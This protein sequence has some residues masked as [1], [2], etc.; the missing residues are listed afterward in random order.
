MRRYDN[1]LAVALTFC[2]GIA[3]YVIANMSDVADGYLLEAAMAIKARPGLYRGDLK[4]DLDR[5]LKCARRVKVTIQTVIGNGRKGE[6]I[7]MDFFDERAEVI[8]HDVDIFH[9]QLKQYLDR[10]RQ[11]DSA[12]KAKVWLALEMLGFATENSHSVINGMESR[13]GIRMRQDAQFLLMDEV[14]KHYE[15]VCRR[16]LVAEGDITQTPTDDKN[17]ML[18]YSIIVK[19]FG[20]P[21]GIVEKLAEAGEMNGL[22]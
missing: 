4:I 15:K 5:A 8:R 17:I 16:I 18:A 22:G 13:Y 7:M 2:R 9:L 12:F 11:S 21:D 1:R 10:H 19:R 14:K 6:Q 20:N 3:M